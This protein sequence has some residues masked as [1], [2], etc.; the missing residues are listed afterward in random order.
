MKTILTNCKIY[1]GTDQPNPFNTIIIEDDKI[2]DIT[3]TFEPTN[4]ATIINLEGLSIAPGFI[5]AHSHNDWFA[6]H[7][8]PIKYFEPFLRQGITSFI[9]GNCG[10]SVSGYRA[11]TAHKEKMGLGLFPNVDT[12]GKYATFKKFFDTIDNNS[13]L[14]IASLVGHCTTRTG[15]SGYENRTLTP[16]EENEMLTTFEQA[17]KEGACG[18]SLG[19]MY[20]PGLYAKPEELK[21]IAKLCEKHNRVLTVHPRACSG[22]S[23]AYPIPFGRSHIL[24]ALDELVTITKG[25]KTKLHYSH[26]I[27]VGRK[28][29][30][31]H[32]GLIQILEQLRKKGVDAMFDIYAEECGVSIITVI[33]P[34][35]FQCLTN[36]DKKKL[37]NITKFK[38][39]AIISK[40]LLGFDFADMMIAYLGDEHTQYE[41]KTV[42]QIAKEKNTSEL[43]TYIYLCE[44]SNYKGRVIIS[45]YSSPE[46]ISK[47]S[48]NPNCLYMTDA[49]VEDKGV[50]NLAIH[51]CFPKFLHLSLNGT[52]DT[53]IN[54]VR[55]MSGAVADRFNISDRGYIRKNHFADL[56]IFD[57][58]ELKST[59]PDQ[60]KPFGIKK[61][62]VNGKPVLDNEKINYTHFK[63]AGRAI[64]V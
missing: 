1:D 35:W 46:I 48:K 53:L 50:Q 59:Q 27:F 29:F 34:A 4:T 38:T 28:S 57:E 58:E 52:G 14:N 15:I 31:A 45:Q 20:E 43:D 42:A 55:K 61:V 3:D 7:E 8:E 21:K 16:Q 18:I 12:T 54:T 23:M 49:W 60:L 22:V 63:N 37:S 6:V 13:P 40:K 56:T 24:K 41:G 36:K 44:I 10:L 33:M 26:A 17:L 2:I 62:F 32:K 9:T 19:L 47:L 64:R 5:D 25:T 51:D 30:K 11:D 39:L